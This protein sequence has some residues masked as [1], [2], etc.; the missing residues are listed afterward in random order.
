M[1]ENEELKSDIF[2][3]LH[4]AFTSVSVDSLMS[5]SSNRN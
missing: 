3:K 1:K 4:L 5:F 2:E